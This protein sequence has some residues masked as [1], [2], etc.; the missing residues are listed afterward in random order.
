MTYLLA[1]PPYQKGLEAYGD[2][3]GVLLTDSLGLCL[4]L[5]CCVEDGMEVDYSEV[6][7][8]GE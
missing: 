4:T 5:V 1:T 7:I 2:P 6:V 3:V 8:G